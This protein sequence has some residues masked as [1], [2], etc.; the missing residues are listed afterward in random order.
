M[1][2]VLIAILLVLFFHVSF[3]QKLGPT[4]IA[5][6]GTEYSVD[7]LRIS[8][9]I[10]ELV[11]PTFSTTDYYL[12]QGYQQPVKFMISGIN[13]D[14]G[15]DVN[16]KIFPNPTSKFVYIKITDM[17]LPVDCQIEVYNMFGQ[18]ILLPIQRSRVNNNG[19]NIK[20][21][22]SNVTRGTYFIRILE[23]EIQKKYTDFKVVKIE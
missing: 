11:V 3:G 19:E 5:S 8:Y 16:V 22:L 18:R 6:A 4:V 9:T 1:K 13:N 14:P 2:T 12:T 21:D 17:S 20:I 7:D 15:T 10:G 23:K